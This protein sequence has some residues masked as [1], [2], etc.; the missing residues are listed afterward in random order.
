MQ[1]QGEAVILALAQISVL[2][3]FREI[4]RGVVYTNGLVFFASLVML[5]VVLNVWSLESRRYS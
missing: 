5:F 2:D 4:E 3:H 1:P